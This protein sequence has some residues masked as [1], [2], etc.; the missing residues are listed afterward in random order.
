V[1][2]GL[3]TLLTSVAAKP[4]AGLAP[5]LP[6]E[7]CATTKYWTTSPTTTPP[8]AAVSIVH[9]KAGAAPVQAVDTKLPAPLRKYT[10]GPLAPVATPLTSAMVAGSAR[11][12]VRVVLASA[13]YVIDGAR[14]SSRVPLNSSAPMSG[15][16][17]LRA[18]PSKSVP[19]P[20]TGTPPLSIWVA[21]AGSTCRTS[22]LAPTVDRNSAFSDIATASRGAMR[23]R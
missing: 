18:W 13:A 15:L 16:V 2:G 8:S 1:V 6:A 14:R 7:S 3:V 20:A 11:F 10:R 9:V 22:A 19:M 17:A 23:A 21:T 5:T 12:V 4:A